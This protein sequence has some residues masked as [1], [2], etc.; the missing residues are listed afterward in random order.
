M[1][2]L[3]ASDDILGQNQARVNHMNTAEIVLIAAV[4]VLFGYV[5]YSRRIAS[6]R[7]TDSSVVQLLNDI[8]RDLDEE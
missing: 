4:L 6:G 3:A 5:F 1:L 2:Y 7:P 8:R